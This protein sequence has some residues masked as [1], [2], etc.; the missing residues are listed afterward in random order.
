MIGTGRLGG[1]GRSQAPGQAKA[2]FPGPRPGAFGVLR[3]LQ[4]LHVLA[5]EV[6]AANTA[7]SQAAQGLRDAGLMAACGYVEEQNRRQQAWLHT[8]L[9]HRATHTLTVPSRMPA[10]N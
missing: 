3:D 4:G 7:V 1:G 8:H 6:H 2:L 10:V 9:L 5:S